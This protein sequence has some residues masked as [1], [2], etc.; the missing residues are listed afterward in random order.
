MCDKNSC[1]FNSSGGGTG[2]TPSHYRAKSRNALR[3]RAVELLSAWRGW[4]GFVAFTIN[5]CYIEFIGG[6]LLLLDKLLRSLQQFIDLT[7]LFH[8]ERTELHGSGVFFYL[9]YGAEA[10]DR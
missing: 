5:S 10:R 4:G 8:R 7:H 6:R 2:E 3:S 1:P 9:C